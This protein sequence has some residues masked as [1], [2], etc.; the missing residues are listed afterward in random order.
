MH[1]NQAADIVEI[2]L[3]IVTDQH[4]CCF[5]YDQDYS[6]RFVDKKF[7][8]AFI[9]SQVVADHENVPLKHLFGFTSRVLRA[10]LT[11]RLRPG[12]QGHRRRGR[13]PRARPKQLP[14]LLHLPSERG[15]PR[16][17]AGVLPL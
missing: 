1:V 13:E 2:I 17:L 4:V 5:Q 8:L 10:F 14:L 6:G 12:L 11:R 16:A 15:R 9:R 3:P 7:N